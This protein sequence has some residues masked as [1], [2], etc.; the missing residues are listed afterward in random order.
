MI[1]HNLL[2][3]VH[4]ARQ[5]LGLSD[6]EYR[7]I[8]ARTV[9]V[10]SA[11]ELT[12]RTVGRVLHEFRRLGWV[13]KPPK[14]AGRQPNTL[15]RDAQLW[16]IEA[17]LCE[18]GAS[19]AYA[20]AIAKQ[21]TGLAKLEWLKTEAQFRGVIAALDVELNKRHGLACVDRECQ[22]LGLTREQLAE[23]YRLPKGWER[24]PR[25][26]D[27]LIEHLCDIQESANNDEDAQ[28]GES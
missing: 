9:G 13:P 18:L 26:L 2:A 14:R 21:Q 28:G 1:P 6:E 15:D 17:L 11:K 3:K 7:A 10:S 4:I 22:R 27:A 20:E 24:K 23:R 25:V 19:W 8:L 12:D 5:E 16:K